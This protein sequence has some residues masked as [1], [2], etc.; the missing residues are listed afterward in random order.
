LRRDYWLFQGYLLGLGTLNEEEPCSLGAVVLA[1][2]LKHPMTVTAEGTT[3][4]CSLLALPPHMRHAISGEQGWQI[5]GYLHPDSRLAGMILDRIEKSPHP[6]LQGPPVVTSRELVLP[7]LDMEPAAY[8]VRE[9]WEFLL[10]RLLGIQ[11]YPLGWSGE[12]KTFLKIVD[13]IPVCDLG[14]A[15]FARALDLEPRA[16]EERFLELCGIP[17]AHYL[18]NRKVVEAAERIR[19]GQPMEAAVSEAGLS[20]VSSV[21]NYMKEFYN[22]DMEVLLMEKPLIR[23]FPAADYEQLSGYTLQN[24]PEGGQI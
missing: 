4:S 23:F 10:S 8:R 18:L 17:L 22:L 7:G 13:S 5:F 21:A 2:S 6:W 19:R 3:F 15:S 1:V 24:N 16:A 12:V 9:L 11:S 14:V 20:G